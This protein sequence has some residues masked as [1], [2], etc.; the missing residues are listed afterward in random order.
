MNPA[1]VYVNGQITALSGTVQNDTG[2]TVTAT[3]DVSITGDIT[4][5]TSPVSIPNDVLSSSTNAGVMGIYTNGNINLNPN[6]SGSNRGNLTVDASLAAIGSGTSGFE[7]PGS[8]IG[9]WT[10]LGGRSEDQAHGVSIGR[11][12][13]YY[14]RRFGTGTFGPPWFPT[15]V[16]Q[17]GAGA[18]PPVLYQL[19]EKRISW[20]ENRS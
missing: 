8:S 7:T 5:I 3:S 12:N 1:L 9:T 10:I 15:A 14:D 18:I 2:I 16:P 13:T 4:Y 19:Q 6:S 11:G 20:S 17:P